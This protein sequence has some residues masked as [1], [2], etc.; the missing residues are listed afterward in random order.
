MAATDTRR[1]MTIQL[2][3]FGQTSRRILSGVL[4]L[5]DGNLILIET[6]DGTVCA[7]NISTRLRVNVDPQTY[8]IT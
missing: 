2:N 4:S 1:S 6:Q 8:V 7:T 5:E 3:V